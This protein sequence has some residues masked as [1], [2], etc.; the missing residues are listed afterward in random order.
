MSFWDDRLQGRCT[1]AL[2]A[3]FLLWA[4]LL[5]F[6]SPRLLDAICWDLCI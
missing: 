2:E 5:W 4:E 1:P 3:N 6:L